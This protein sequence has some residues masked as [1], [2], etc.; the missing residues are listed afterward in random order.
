[1]AA[2]QVTKRE[3]TA[4]S[5]YF[6]R[7]L[8]RPDVNCAWI[9]QAVCSQGSLTGAAWPLLRHCPVAAMGGASSIVRRVPPSIDSKLQTVEIHTENPML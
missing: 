5:F 3:M 8:V 6:S 2:A 7:L 1:M 9:L 4:T